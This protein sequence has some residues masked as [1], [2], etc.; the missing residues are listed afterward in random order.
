MKQIL[1]KPI[2][3]EK[4]M[5]LI[6]EN[7]YTFEVLKKSNKIEI[8]KT[9]KQEFKVNAIKVNIINIKSK[10]KNALRANRGKTRSWQKAV[11]TIEKGQ[12]I[13]GFDVKEK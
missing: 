5:N 2:V 13:P 8:A 9:I 1:I 11:V 4:T 10:T 6:P 7:K 3:S 12:K